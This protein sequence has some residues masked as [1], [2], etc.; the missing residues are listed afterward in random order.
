MDAEKL[1]LI[2]GLQGVI[3]KNMG[4]PQAGDLYYCPRGSEGHKIKTIEEDYFDSMQYGSDGYLGKWVKSEPCCPDIILLVPDL[5]SRDP[6][7]PERGFWGMVDWDKFDCH[8]RGG[9]IY[10]YETDRF[11]REI[12]TNGWCNPYL[13]LLKAIKWQEE[14]KEGEK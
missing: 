5:Y 9:E 6:D 10:I 14:S 11:Q 2:R 1:D 13:A 4:E 8:L 7:R 3:R 12:W